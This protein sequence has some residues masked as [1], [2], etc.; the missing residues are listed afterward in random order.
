MSLLTLQTLLGNE[1]N[2]MKLADQLTA[3][4][5][6][7]V[8]TTGQFSSGKLTT[9]MALAN[10]IAA[11]TRPVFVLADQEQLIK[12]YKLFPPNWT[13]TI[14]P[15]RQG[16][17][18]FFDTVTSA[19]AVILTS[20]LT[21]DNAK[22]AAGAARNNLVLGCVDTPLIGLDVAYALRDM[23]LDYGMAI[24]TVRCIW[25]QALL[26]AL[27]EHCSEPV[28]LT[29]EE[30]EYLF[31]TGN[32][33]PALKREVG[34]EKCEWSGN[35]GRTALCDVTL[36]DD[37]NRRNVSSFLMNGTRLSLDEEHHVSMNSQARL[38]LNSGTLGVGTYRDMILRNPL[39]RSQNILERERARS[40]KLG[41]LFDK[42]VSPSVKQRLLDGDKTTDT[43]IKGESRIVTCLFCDMRDFTPRAESR[44][45][46]QLF[47]ELNRYFADVVDAVL[48]NEG[49][50][51]KFIGDAVMAVF[52]APLDQSDHAERAV[53]CALTIQ[54]RI[55]TLNQTYCRDLPMAV[56]IGIN[57]GSAIAG[58]LGTDERM[59]YTV[60]GD[61]V[62]IA[63]RLEG[64]AEPG[65]ILISDSTRR[66]IA[67]GFKLKSKGPMELKGKSQAVDVFEVLGKS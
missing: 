41:Y 6:G 47:A 43:I 15:S 10:H 42:F 44:D 29:K 12:S 37:S 21:V 66:N 46:Q 32:A 2:L 31:P 26:P 49:T 16:Q 23:Q 11:E 51:D 20:Q 52:G 57:T 27:C 67:G 62:N 1:E 50:I 5:S 56:G 25:S 61:A 24:D 17:A 65:Q 34:C 13:V 4:K 8:L 59:E 39:L 64:Q 53:K 3:L 63:A 33:F 7:M 54:Q 22:A 36:I 38:F 58:C 19:D 48:T 35:S 28:T 60:L 14:Q 40:T 30:S 18:E 55:E 9:L 45:P